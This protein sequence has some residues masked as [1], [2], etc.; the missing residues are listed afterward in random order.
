[1]GSVCVPALGCLGLLLSSVMYVDLHFLFAGNV[2][3]IAM[4]TVAESILAVP[5]LLIVYLVKIAS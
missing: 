4:L 1:M 5:D 3:R 2:W